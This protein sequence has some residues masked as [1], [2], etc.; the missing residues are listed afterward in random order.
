MSVDVDRHG[1]VAVITINR[2]EAA[3]SLDGETMSGLGVAFQAA[4]RDDDVRAVILTG[5]GDRVFCAGMDL[6][7]FATSGTP[8]TD[9]PG[10]EI[11]TR[12]VFPKPVI[13]ALNGSAVAGG[14]ELALACDLIVMAD[15][16]RLGLPE[17]KRG[18]V[19]A[20]GGTRLPRRLPFAIAL[21]LG[22]T[23]SLISAQEALR[24]SLVN[25][26]EPGSRVL[27]TALE[28]AATISDNGPLAVQATKQLMYE[29]L[30]PVD[31]EHLAQTAGPVFDSDDAKEGARSFAE[32]RPPRWSGV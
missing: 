9:G 32:K 5:A 31:W 22:L 27:A 4:E 26:V 21:E 6:K 24:F 10:L 11:F 25:R 1:A 18:L 8:T 30:G 15:H 2:P 14:F 23:G 20:G 16:A 19:A 13:G 28:L 7:A 17:V 3:N 29:E 12:R